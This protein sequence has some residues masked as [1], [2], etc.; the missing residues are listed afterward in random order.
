[1]QQFIVVVHLATLQLLLL[2]L[3]TDIW[4]S[5]GC[6]HYAVGDLCFY[7]IVDWTFVIIG[8]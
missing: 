1:M 4:S 7:Y 5:W 3:L 6:G 2:L 8:C